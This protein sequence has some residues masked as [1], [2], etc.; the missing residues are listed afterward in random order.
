[1]HKIFLESEFING[2]EIKIADDNFKHIKAL[3][4][5]VGDEI[6]ICDGEMN[7][8]FCTVR[9]IS[10]DEALLNINQ[11]KKSDTEPAK[12]IYLFQALPKSDKFELI[13]QKAVELGVYK[14]IP[15]ICEYCDVKNVPSENKFVRWQKIS[16]SASEQSGRGIVPEISQALDFKSA[17]SF[18][19]NI[20]LNFI[21]HE[22]SDS[23]IKNYFAACNSIGVF[24]GP[25][26]GFSE[27]EI[28]H[29]TKNNINAVS[30]GKR[31][32]RTETAA[33]FV[34]SLISI[35]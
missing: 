23:S 25:E 17:V 3:R 26:G 13:I 34:L 32:L 7:D 16:K 14:I 9:Q 15:V 18:S 2:N 4:K 8:Y 5:K 20:D 11:I 28:E 31:I 12:K 10:K 29:A 30:L 21:A 27:K 35:F 22:K 1:M 6:I 19:N 24:I 33:I